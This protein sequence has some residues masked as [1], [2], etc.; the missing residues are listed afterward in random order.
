MCEVANMTHPSTEFRLLQQNKKKE[1]KNL[2]AA[3]LLPEK[4]FLLVLLEQI[5]G[6]SPRWSELNPS[7]ARWLSWESQMSLEQQKK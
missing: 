2:H 6:T 7:S 3:A 4:L 5:F 1:K